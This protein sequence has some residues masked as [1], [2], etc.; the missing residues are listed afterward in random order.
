MELTEQMDPFDAV[1][2]FFNRAATIAMVSAS[3]EKV[4]ET[5]HRE[6]RVEVQVR[7]DSG[8]LETYIGYRVQHDN[9]RGPFKGGV[10]FHP[11]AAIE[12]VRALASLMTWKTA[13]VDVPFGGAKGGIAVDV[14]SFS[15]TELE[16]L[17]R[18]YVRQI[19]RLIGPNTD[20]PAPDMYTNEQVMAWFLDEYEQ[21]HGHSPGVVTGKPLALGGSPGRLEATGRGA[22]IVLNE[23]LLEL[24]WKP[25][26]TTV[27]IQGFGNVGSWAGRLAHN[28]GYKVVAV[29]DRKGC[30]YGENGLDIDALL[31]HRAETGAME[32]FPDTE[33][34]PRDDVLTLPV[35]VLI[36]AALG[37]VIHADN[38]EHIRAKVILE[39]ANHPVTPWADA[40]LTERGITIVPDILANAGGVTVSYFEWVQNMQHF[41]WTLTQVNDQLERRLVEAQRHVVRVARDRQCTL[42]EA[43][44][45]IAVE[46]VAEASALRGLL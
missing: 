18:F 14:R 44:F 42:R 3:T 7:R 45:V 28:A 23:M 35:D 9:S 46:R 17:T 19:S 30:L 25:D 1:N 37:E 13:L 11:S 5:P 33:L 39:G 41:R 38:A 12:E 22:V 34:L 40:V 10:R 20:I 26:E 2:Y 36:P 16:R 43:A 31:V 6:L 32:G 21:L 27:A 15:A 4:L 8:V 29:S 24:D